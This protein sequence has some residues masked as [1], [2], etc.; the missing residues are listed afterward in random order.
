[1]RKQRKRRWLI[2]GSGWAYVVSARQF[3]AACRLAFREAI[4]NGKIGRQPPTNYHGGFSR[5][6]GSVVG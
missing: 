3:G 5:V 2:R 6:H 1:M 4:G